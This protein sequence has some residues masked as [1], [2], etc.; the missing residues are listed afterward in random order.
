MLC[1]CCDGLEQAA[2]AAIKAATVEAKCN[3][4]NGIGVVKVRLRPL[5]THEIH[6]H[7]ND[8][9]KDAKEA[10]RNRFSLRGLLVL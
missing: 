5:L 7:T 9:T 1:V 3:I 10:R 2:Q 6:L 4:P 8:T